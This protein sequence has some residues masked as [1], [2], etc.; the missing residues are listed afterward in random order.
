MKSDYLRYQFII[1]I[2]AFLVLLSRVIFCLK[3]KHDVQKG[4]QNFNILAELRH[5]HCE[6]LLRGWEFQCREMYSPYV[7]R[8][9]LD[10]NLNALR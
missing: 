10:E 3:H 2:F 7:C 9:F 5:H 4:D 6:K 8:H 1:M